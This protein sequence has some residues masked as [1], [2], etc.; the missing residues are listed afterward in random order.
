M[1]KLTLAESFSTPSYIFDEDAFASQIKMIAKYLPNIPLCYSIKANP[2]LIKSIPA[3]ITH[4]EVCSP[5]E[6]TICEKSGID[7][8][9]IIFSGVNKTEN[10]VERAMSDNVGVFTAESKKHLQLINDCAAKY[11]KKVK[12]IL[13]LSCGNQFGMDE[14]ELKAFINQR[15]CYKNVDIIGIHYYTGTQKIKAAFIRKELEKL[16]AVLTELKE[17]SGFEPELVEY[18]PGLACNYFAENSEDIDK[19][20]LEEVAVDLLSFAEKYPLGIEMGRYIASSC[21]TYYTKVEDIKT[22]HGINYAIC[23]GGIHHLK[24]Y[25][26][27]MSMQVPPLEVLN[28][29]NDKV[30]DWSLCGSLCTTADVFVR[31]VSLTGLAEGSVLKFGKCGAYSV[32]EA[33]V[34][35]LS[36]PLPEIYLFSEEKGLRKIRER[37]FSDTINR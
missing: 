13:R 29:A 27:T 30:L 21:G 20:L 36:R 15:D 14:E 35:F 24:Y 19:Q 1:N 33:P 3:E 7:L 10:D 22:I 23:D 18:G 31:K 25:G 17:A 11:G 32:T 2:F 16:D 34:L 28:P 26:Q 9:T 6:L 37:I 4:V 5:G 12:L 8:E